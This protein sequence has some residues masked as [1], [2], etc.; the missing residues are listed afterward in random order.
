MKKAAYGFLGLIVLLV[1]AAL[2]VPSVIDWNGYKTEITAEVRKATGRTLDIAGDIEF[3]VL[4]APRLR[5]SGARLS[6]APGATASHMVSLKELRVSVA[7]LPLFQG[8]IEIGQVELIDPV[9][10]LEKLPSGQMNWLFA[11]DFAADSAPDSVGESAGSTGSAANSAL[12]SSGAPAKSDAGPKSS[13]S[14]FKLDA[15]TIINGTIVYRDT[16]SATVE[17]IEKLTADISAGSLTGPFTFRGG[18]TFRDTP[19]TVTA[20]VRRLVENGAV[21]FRMTLGTPAT[22]AEIGL[23]GTLTDVETKLSISAKL[24]GKGDNLGALLASLTRSAPLPYL[25]QAFAV[26]ATVAGSDEAVT[27]NDLALQLGASSAT[28]N[29]KI[30]LRDGVRADIALRMP[31]LD[32][33]ALMVAATR[34]PPT[35]TTPITPPTAT[36]ST[37]DQAAA[38]PS[39]PDAQT[40]TPAPKFKL[41]GDI[42]A[43]IDLTID[44]VI[45]MQDRVRA[46]RLAASLRDGAVTLNTLTAGFPGATELSASGTLTAPQGALTYAGKAAIRSTNLRRF[47]TW[48]GVDIAAVPADRLRRF[49]VSADVSGNAE[50]VQAVGIVAQL[51]ASRM[52]G[53]LT[54]ALRDRAA[55]GASLSIDQINADAYIGKPA[56]AA[57]E[58]VLKE[59]GETPA[60]PGQDPV[61]KP[62][63]KGPF[64]VLNDFD[65]N[66]TFRVGSLSYQRMAIQGVRLDG[67]LVNGVLT[68]RDASVR[69]LAGTS[70]QVKGTLSGLAGIPAFNGTVAA[71]SDDLTGLF[72]IAGIEPPVSPRKLG[73]MRLTSRT[74]VSKSG[75]TI[76]ASLQLAEVT[77]KIAGKVAGLAASP[78][79]DISV[80]A[81]HPEFARL[82]NLF[83]TGKPGP[84]VG[85]VGLKMTLKG[86]ARAVALD[87]NAGVAGGAFKIAGTINTPLEVPKFDISADIKH[88]N[89]VRFVRAFD[90]GFKPANPRLGG[91]NMAV[92]LAGSEENLAISG[93]TGK[94]GPTSI[95]GQGS[96]RAAKAGAGR[97]DVKLSL[98]T[99]T[100]PLSDFLEA[101]PGGN[102]PQNGA[103]TQQG[104]RGGSGA[105]ATSVKAGQRWSTDPIDTDALGLVDANIDLRAE[106]VL[107]QTF[108]IDQPKIVA[109]LK[110]KVLD[111][112]QVTGTMFDGG[113]EMRG[114]VDG[115]GVPVATTSLTITKANVGKALFQAAEFDI[116]TGILSVGMDLSARGESQF[117][118]IKALS[119]KGKIDV[120]DGVVKGFDLKTAS[121]NLNNINQL[122][123]LLGVLSSA[124]NGGET[125]FSSLKG[126]FE[127][128]KGIIIT[129]DLALIADAGAGNARG[130]VNLPKWNMDMFA[131]FRLTEHSSAPPF[132]VRAV[133]APDNPRRLFDFQALQAWVLQRGVGGL[134]Q[135]LVPGANN[136][137]GSQQQ[138]QQQPKP[139]DIIRGY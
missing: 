34:S 71:A 49:N 30:A 20:E 45:A 118:M 87:V 66:L 38:S 129:N 67:T 85:R 2:I 53:G 47:L 93:L 64:A 78:V 128:T 74:D 6:N 107:Y 65:A 26:S 56:P 23:T 79:L 138:Q 62:E 63:S 134:I 28:G 109:V 35:I 72:K 22:K 91:L 102:R 83:A 88:P 17:R 54:V 29:I 39:T 31:S 110:D 84:A 89:L 124:M 136:S 42:E 135:K 46:V 55:F 11:A 119:G 131:D 94:I 98:V 59:G 100:I 33:D 25:G 112:Q 81:K 52:S 95:S 96:Y 12:K 75:L 126:T 41:P 48:A 132:R 32:A 101:P 90:P 120:V 82:A 27:V 123:G 97:P 3:T 1:A 14:A 50:Q 69:N 36:S 117:D 61:P 86:D 16:A 43:N 58:P 44:E 9:I 139:E 111:I 40:V 108:R 106:A 24:D 18:L 60:A 114:K 113:F 137:G 13:A 130:F 92:K 105:G 70:A 68:L 104:A 5:I 133:G 10:E 8:D 73:K 80:D 19:L 7:L 125:Q 127:I 21:P 77:A 37:P 15:L 122:A 51:D 99:S 121:D 4:P 115:R 76:D 57:S 116:A 103:R